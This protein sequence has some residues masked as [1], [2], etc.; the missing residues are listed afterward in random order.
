M[1]QFVPASYTNLTCPVCSGE[2][3]RYYPNGNS[4]SPF[5]ADNPYW[6]QCTPCEGVGYSSELEPTIEDRIQAIEDFL[7]EL[8]TI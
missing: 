3:Q 1:T 8:H 7:Q 6:E 2:G 4:P 5:P